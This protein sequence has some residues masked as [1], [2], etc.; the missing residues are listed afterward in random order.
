ML[1]FSRAMFTLYEDLR[2]SLRLIAGNRTVSL[3]VFLSLTLGIGASASMFGAADAFLF[4][5]IQAPQTDRILRLTSVTKS[6]SVDD[7]S[8]P[9]F[10]D[11]QKRATAFE[12]IATARH[13]SDDWVFGAAQIIG[14]S[15][16]AV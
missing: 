3:A 12:S 4:R 6:S 9:D 15:A 5:P 11:L 2:Y 10:D 16:L 1:L 7:V 14:V 8:Y 13:Q